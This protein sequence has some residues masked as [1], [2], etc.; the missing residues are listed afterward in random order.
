[1]TAAVLSGTALAAQLR[2]GTASRAAALAAAGR[3]PA[4]AVVTAT[5]DEGSAWY[6]ATIVKSAAKAAIEC[7]VVD[8]GAA[9]SERSIRSALRELSDDPAVAGVILQT[10]V[11]DGLSAAALAAGIAP[12]KD[13]DGANP[14]SLGRL[15]AGL[16]AFAP[17]TAEAV[18]RLLDFHQVALAGRDA[19]IVGRS[20]VVGKPLAQLLL[21]RDATVTVAHS[22]SRDLAHVTGRADVLV[23]AAGRAHLVTPAHV[24]P[25]AVI[26]D[27]GTNVTRQ[28][29]L[30]GDVDPGVGATAAAISPVPGGVGPVTTAVLL[31]HAVAAAEHAASS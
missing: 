25:G 14:L 20:V 10:P 6:V 15:S 26:I 2:A 22:R 11:P 21:S 30:V 9:A 23:A 19:V 27:V 16:P 4:V 17:A 24:R 28:G 5:S 31:E 3:P 1:M 12:A 29:A 8:L 13:I 18:I 7:R